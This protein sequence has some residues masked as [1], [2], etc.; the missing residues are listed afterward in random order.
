LKKLKICTGFWIRKKKF[1]QLAMLRSMID[2]IRMRVL[3]FDVYGTLVDVQ[4]LHEIAQPFLGEVTASFL[5]RW[6]EKTVEYAF[7]RGLMQNYTEFSECNRQALEYVNMELKAGLS[8]EI[9]ER[10]LDGHFRLPAFSDA[11]AAMPRL[12]RLKNSC[13]AFS[14]GTSLAVERVLA[15]TNL[16]GYFSEIVSVDDVHTFKPSPAV[17]AYL[18]RRVGVEARS[19]WLISSNGWDVIGAKSAGL[20]TVW[21]QR[22]PDQIFDPWGYEPDAIVKDLIECACFFE[23]GD[24]KNFG[25]GSL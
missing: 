10:L 8:G 4:G 7:R 9:K 17:Y 18:T 25:G 5:V 1:V 21:V 15:A 11:L 24:K 19:I 14:N 2:C 6:R 12:L 23:E 22:N 3:A 16:V 13:V 20:R